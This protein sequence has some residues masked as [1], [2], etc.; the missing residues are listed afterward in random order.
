VP[1]IIVAGRASGFDETEKRANFAIYKDVDI[2]SQLAKALD[3]VMGEAGRGQGA[4]K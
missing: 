3:A 1:I 2:D 4:A